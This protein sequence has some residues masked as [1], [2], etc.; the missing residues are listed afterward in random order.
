M[1]NPILTHEQI[2]YKIRRI[3]FQIYEANVDEEVIILAGIEGGGLALTRKIKKV[4]EEI[5]PAEILLC[6]VRMDKANPLQSG[7]ETSLKPEQYAN[8]SVVL[9]DD[10]LSTGSTLIYGVHHFIKTPLRQLKTAVLINRNFKRFPVKADFKG[11]SLSTSHH[12]HVRV[13]F[14]SRKNAVY[15]E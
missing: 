13:D 1:D 15:L 11:I 2:Q 14:A 10:V 8:R 4:L 5:T 3:A 7:V 9:I 6:Q 12:E